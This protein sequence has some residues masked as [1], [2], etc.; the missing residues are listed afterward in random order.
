MESKVKF[1]GHAVHPA[2]V[3]LPLGLYITS[4]VFDVISLVTQDDKFADASDKMIGAGVVSGAVAGV[5][6]LLDWQ[7]IP[8]GTRAKEIGAVHGIGNGLVTTLFA[9]S[10]LIRR[11]ARRKPEPTAIALSLLGTTLG[12]VTGWLGGEL[13]QRLG[14]GIDEGANLNAPNSLTGHPAGEKWDDLIGYKPEGI[15]SSVHT[16]MR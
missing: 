8:S 14:V 13:V 5:F 9:A 2:L 3:A 15:L 12:G 16:G 11:N 10:W 6:G 4:T 1:M 7:T